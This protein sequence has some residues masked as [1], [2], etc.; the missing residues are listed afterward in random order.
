MRSRYH[1]EQFKKHNPEKFNTLIN[2]IIADL[3]GLK[4]SVSL[5]IVSQKKAQPSLRVK[6]EKDSNREIET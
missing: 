5:N 1:F 6:Y 4:K 2:R 3:S